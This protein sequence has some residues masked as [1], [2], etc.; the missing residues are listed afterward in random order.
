MKDFRE[1]VQTLLELSDNQWGIYAFD[2]DPLEGKF[3]LEEKRVYIDKANECGR[4]TARAKSEKYREIHKLASGLGVKIEYSDATIGGGHI[5]FAQFI[6][7]NQITIFKKA[8]DA[9]QPFFE[10]IHTLTGD[11]D[12]VE[13]LLAHEIFHCIEHIEE[14]TIYTR[15]EK[16]ELWRW[17]FSNKSRIR[18]L[19]E[20][21]GM[22][23][24]KEFLKL[25]YSPFIFDFIFMYGYDQEVAIEMY[26]DIVKSNRL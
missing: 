26:E 24:T 22:A 5:V 16:V 1:M 9:I 17:P 20:I 7:P 23:F 12:I 3:S 18:A 2:R 10:E 11:V 8:V 21:A 25:S 19:S 6:E 15:T 13:V 14:Q 4:K